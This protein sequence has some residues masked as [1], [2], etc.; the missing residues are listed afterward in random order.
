L[1]FIAFEFVEGINLRMLLE[2]RGRL[3]VADA[4]RIILQIA[5][6]LEHA[7]SRGVVHRDVKPSNIIISPN[8]RAKLVDMG[9]ARSLEPHND[10]ALTQ[11]GVTLGTFD[12]IS[13]EQA[14]EP[15]EADSR[16]DV[17]SLGC[18]FYHML[19]GQAPVPE[20][21]A[22]RKLH[23]HQHLAPIDPRQLS[24]DTPDEVAAVLGRMMA[25]D[26]KDR[27]QRPVHLVQHLLQVAQ[28]VG[29][30]D[31]V[32]EGV[33]FVDTPLSGD[34]RKRPLLLVSLGA[35]ALALI[36]ALLSLAPR[37]RV[38]LP[39][40]TPRAHADKTT[41]TKDAVV[42]PL[43]KAGVHPAA[44]GKYLI[45]S[46]QDLEKAVA[47]GKDAN[48]TLIL[49]K[50]IDL[51][52]GGLILAGDGKSSVTITCE[53]PYE[54]KSIRYKYVPN[55]DSAD[56]IAGLTLA[57][58]S[59]TFQNILFEIDAGETPEQT[60]AALGI[61]GAAKV[62]FQNCTFV[63]KEVPQR[64]FIPQLKTLVPVACVAI[65]NPGGDVK[66]RPWVAFEQC[67]FKGGQAAVS[68]N[69]PAE[70]APTDCA[71][72]R[73]GALFHLRGDVPDHGIA[74]KVKR[75]D[76]LVI[77]GPAF[78]LDDNATCD[79]K[80]EYS[81]FSRPDKAPAEKSDEQDLIRQ[82]SATEALVKFEGKRN[83]YH[84]LN[85]L[86]VR[87]V[88]LCT[89]LDEFRALALEAGG[90]DDGS[91][92][93]TRDTPI[94]VAPLPWNEDS[95]GAFQ[96]LANVREI[97]R[98][99]GKALG[100]E[101]CLNFTMVLEALPVKET[102]TAEIKLRP[103]DKVVDP[104]ALDSGPTVFKT[105]FQAAALAKPG[106][107][108]LIKHGKS[109][110][111]PVAPI[112][113]NGELILENYPGHAPVLQMDAT[114]DPDAAFFKMTD[115]NLVIEHLE[116]LLREP[117]QANFKAQAVVSMGG[118]ASCTFRDCVFSLRPSETIMHAKRAPLSL[119]TLADPEEAMKMPASAATRAGAEI[120]LLNCF[121]R[122]EGEVV[123]VRGNRPLDLDVNNTMIALAGSLLG[124]HAGAKEPASEAEAKIRLNHVS[125][126]LTEPLLAFYAGKNP[127]GFIPAHVDSAQNSLFVSLAEKP[128]V[129]IEANE[130]ADGSLRD[131]LDWKGQH[132]AYG[133][134]E[135]MLQ[136]IRPDDEGQPFLNMNANRWTGFFREAD[137][138]YLAAPISF[139]AL[140]I[141]SL[142]TALPD[143]F[144]PPAELGE[145]LMAFGA[146]L[147]IDTLPGLA[148]NRGEGRGAR[149]AENAP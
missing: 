125:A 94:W 52:E 140:A 101:K 123:T 96:P 57:G 23:H 24:P 102:K 12:Y 37:G 39:E 28:K 22:A 11:S 129:L 70:V 99:D 85:A 136:T 38:D 122:G 19:T 53:D 111:V 134:Y 103:N 141:K 26:P 66:E 49:R 147:N 44:I 143:Q 20:G 97:R 69:G 54:P 40:K 7:A 63:Q 84:N 5:T 36:L 62:K 42:T 88:T 50:S 116:F 112:T 34:P 59:V 89:E 61:K 81:I 17:Y 107:R 68:I 142:W 92:A 64:K 121:I 114:Q 2:E 91:V 48:C 65:D 128:L 8:G 115:G 137:S 41:I 126:F 32:P 76:A 15:R 87:G 77:G 51:P 109:R 104:D 13:P 33:L 43:Q 47:E 133:N 60:V 6:G 148:R 3:P 145:D 79:L 25:K 130:F 98:A 71:F 127:K 106:D 30:M 4:V 58:G 55:L 95:P 46:D 18:T 117:E 139:G 16:S 132:N 14:L 90:K 74:L 118:A 113:L 73:Y 131:Y 27:Y 93:L 105:L 80:V 72:M 149:G 31:D 120:H 9:L 1:H 144:A 83:C 10:G 35:L 138:R 100:F 75:C 146:N 56:F 124:I 135:K 45:T 21:T 108:I 86:W 119:I 78:R 67:F 29:A 110:T 82:T